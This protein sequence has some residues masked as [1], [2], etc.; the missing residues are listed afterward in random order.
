MLKI[1]GIQKTSMID[2][3]GKMCTILFTPGCNFK[4]P[5]CYNK[6]LVLEPGKLPEIPQDE[7]IEFLKKRKKWID[8]VCITGGEPLIHE[9]IGLLLK[10]IKDIGF[11]VKID[12]NG[13]NPDLLKKL[14]DKKLVDYVAMDIKNSLEEYDVT[15]SSKV[16]FNKIKKSIEIIKNSGIDY[17]FRITAVKRF[18]TKEDFEKISEL[19]KC[20]KSEISEHAQKSPVSDGR[21]LTGTKIF[22]IQNFK[23]LPEVIDQ[24]INKEKPFSKT[25]LEEFKKILEKNIDKVE[26][27]NV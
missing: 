3:P 13:T 15:T 21:F 17:E 4:C 20:Q 14:I 24:T 6:A 7:V 23:P 9:D 2:Y 10:K 25:E 5:F 22:Y 12:T 16:D 27:R 11:L 19:L 8:G 1:K 18:H 26:I